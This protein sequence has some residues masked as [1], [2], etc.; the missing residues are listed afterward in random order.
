[1]V[2]V[3][4]AG[5]VLAIDVD[6]EAPVFDLADVGLVGDWREIVP[7]L[8]DAIAQATTTAQATPTTEAE[9]LEV[10]R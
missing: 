8:A 5:T 1:M 9:L 7:A 10:E 2:G 3:T 6:P 4:G